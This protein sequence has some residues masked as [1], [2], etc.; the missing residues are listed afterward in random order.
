MRTN[1][2]S[3]GNSKG[4]RIPAAILKQCNIADHVELEVEKDKIILKP[5]QIKPREKWD[6]AFKLMH[7]RKEDVLLLNEKIDK[8]M[9]DWEWK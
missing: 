8:E 6:E 7:E 2:V 5:V 4:I 1:L 9:E 3:I